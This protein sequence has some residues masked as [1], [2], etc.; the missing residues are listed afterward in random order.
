VSEQ[1]IALVTDPMSVEALTPF[2]RSLL[3]ELDDPD[4]ATGL[5]KRLGTTRQRV[6]YHLRALEDAGL[7]EL[8]EVRQ[9]RGLQ[10]RLMRRS[11]DVVVVD[12]TAFGHLEGKDR[13]GV[14]GVVSTA[15]DLIRQAATVG[16]EASRAGEKVAAG[17][18]DTVVRLKDPK[19]LRLMLEEI[20]SVV[21]KYDSGESG[22]AV[23]VATVAL[24]APRVP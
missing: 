20:A 1:T 21:A 14:V 16:S 18:L 17:T 9:R 23:R 7:V 24:A 12:P 4:S 2:R 11:G 19:S 8:D 6:N 15:S 22:L 5:A 13:T 3:R 10:E